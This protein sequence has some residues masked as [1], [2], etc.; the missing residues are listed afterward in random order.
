MHGCP[1]RIE[2]VDLRFRSKAQ[3]K[4]APEHSEKSRTDIFGLSPTDPDPVDERAQMPTDCAAGAGG[5]WAGRGRDSWP[6]HSPGPLDVRSEVVVVPVEITDY[7]LQ[8]FL[9]AL[10]GQGKA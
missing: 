7:P 8:R 2:G 1:A 6:V 4:L 5:T 3:A 10:G 9:Q